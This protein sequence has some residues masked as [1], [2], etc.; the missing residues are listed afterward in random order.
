MVECT[1]FSPLLISMRS[2][3]SKSISKLILMII[4]LSGMFFVGKIS[5]TIPTDYIANYEIS[6]D[7]T[8]ILQLL[9]EIES[10]TKI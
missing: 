3:F 2:L 6:S 9:V 7:Y 10:A 1:G 5:A 4:V 8:K